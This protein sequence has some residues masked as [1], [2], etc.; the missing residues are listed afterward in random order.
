MDVLVA[1]W[2]A[3]FPQL[4]GLGDDLL[5][6]WDEPHR[7]YH[8]RRHL[9][10]CLSALDEL[11]GSAPAEELAVWFHDVIYLGAPED[12]RASARLAR[13][14][15]GGEGLQASLVDEV[16]RLVMVT[17]RHRPGWGDRAAQR[18]SDADL[19]IFGAEP[20]RYH[21]SVADLQREQAGLSAVQWRQLRV[22]YLHELQARRSIYAGRQAHE[23]WHAQ[24]KVNISAELQALADS[25]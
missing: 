11:G 2:N 19:A 9:A 6:R 21:Q 12:L 13:Q 14:L 5:V 25:G 8:D 16:A 7:H 20:S 17:G 22:R 18:V 24:A 3:H 23:L 15:L 4:R 1:R 10:E